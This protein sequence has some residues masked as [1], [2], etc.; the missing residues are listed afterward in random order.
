MPYSHSNGVKI[1]YEVHGEGPPMVLVHANPFDRR[2][3]L[4]QVAR[5]SAFHRV[6]AV[7]LRGYGHSDKPETAFT[8]ADMKD[9]VLGVCAD[10]GI[11]RAIFMGV[12]VG[13]GIAMLTALDHPEMC[14]A[15][16]LVG[17]SSNGP[18]DV[19]AIV[20]PMRQDTL[21]A[22]LMHLMRGYVAPGFADT[23]LGHWALSLFTQN[24]AN[25]SAKSIAQIFRARGS[26]DMTARLPGMKIPTLVVNG[27]H[28]ESLARGAITASLIPGAKHAVIPDA[29]HAC[30]IEDPDAFDAHVI[31]FLSELGLWRGR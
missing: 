15:I 18:R 19:E 9:D 13:S 28:D 10:E 3:W 2:L 24:A 16:V 27:Q 11:S 6:I 25:L 30:V 12:S 20:G 8:L 5:Y 14:E 1:H 17:G 7:D 31:G 29:G 26:C 21:G 22:Y 4:Y 23:K